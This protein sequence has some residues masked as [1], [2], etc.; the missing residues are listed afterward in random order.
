MKVLQRE[1]QLNIGCPFRR[2]NGKT[3]RYEMGDIK[4]FLEGQPGR[5]GDATPRRRVVRNA[6]LPPRSSP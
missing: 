5:G 1:R 3:I 6:G 4:A 2:I